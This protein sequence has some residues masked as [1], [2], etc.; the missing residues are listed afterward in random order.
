MYPA[1]IV[2]K[3][4]VKENVGAINK[5][6]SDSGIGITGVIKGCNGMVEVA[7]AFL[8]EGCR[9]IGS[10]RIE[11]LDEIKKSCPGSDTMLVRIPMISEVE[12]MIGCCDVSLQSEV[13]IIE[14]IDE[15]CGQADTIHKVVLMMDLGDLREGYIK[16][17]ELVE[18]AVH[19]EKNLE[20]IRLAGVGTNLGCY[21]SVKPTSKNLGELCD[22]ACEIEE[23]IGRSL[24]I[25]SGGSTSSIPLIFSGEMP[26]KINNLRVGE[27]LLTGRELEEFYG[28]KIE[29]GCM[30]AFRLKAEIVE[31]KNKPTHPIGELGYDA[32]GNTPV[33]ED[34]GNRDR[35]I[36][37]VGRQDFG[38]HDKLIPISGGIEIAGSSSDHLIVEK[39]DENVNFKLGDILEFELMYPA[40]LYISESPYVKKKVVQHSL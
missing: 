16:R 4:K 25:V 35:I 22:I 21:G 12:K 40:L 27:A 36:L 6:C 2:D 20:N 10:S 24:E 5:I 37:A 14:K 9:Y 28:Y 1:L 17:E 29:G 30:N 33:Y 13:E 32:F 3:E 19:I 26:S 11:Q 38:S 39:V 23:R 18:A 34:R 8:S 31:I 15:S 7:E